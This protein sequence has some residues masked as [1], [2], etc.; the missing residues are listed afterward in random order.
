MLPFPKTLLRITVAGSPGAAPLIK[1]IVFG[2][3]LA[4]NTS[5]PGPSNQQECTSVMPASSVRSPRR[6]T[7]LCLMKPV[8]ASEL[9]GSALLPSVK[10]ST[11]RGPKSACSPPPALVASF[12]A[13]RQFL[14]SKR[15]LCAYSPPPE[16]G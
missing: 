3:L 12:P 8:S 4:S 7:L 5:A 2:S 9:F 10:P 1:S 6:S 13:T 11:V 16:I 15:A 14:I